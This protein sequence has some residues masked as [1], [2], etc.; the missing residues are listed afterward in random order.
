MANNGM[1][2]LGRTLLLPFPKLKARL[3]RLRDAYRESGKAPYKPTARV[4][5][6]HASGERPLDPFHLEEAISD[7]EEKDRRIEIAVRC[8][9][10]DDVP[11][12]AEAGAVHH[13]ED[14]TRVQIMHNGLRVLADGYYGDWNTRLIELCH[15]CHEPQEERV[16]HEVLQRLSPKATMIELGGYWAFYSLW[17]LSGGKERT[18]IVVEP[19]PKHLA[20]GEANA[21]LNGLPITFVQGFA[22][23]T[24]LPPTPFKTL[25]SG[26][27]PVPRVSVQSL[28]ENHGIDELNVLHCDIQGAEFEV[29]QGCQPLFRDRRIEF[30]FVSTHYFGPE[31]DPLIHQ[32]CLALILNC[33]GK[34]V[35]EHDVHESF[36]C[37]G[38][39]VAYFGDNS[40]KAGPVP[41]SLNRYSQ[42]YFRNP[43]YDV[44]IMRR[45][46]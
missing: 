36:S 22:G 4:D 9:D 2:A 35:A 13:L 25:T 27:I 42:T 10:M 26:E 46:R 40:E 19:D 17:F 5:F 1:L 33:G 12:V 45:R 30:L 21:R 14:G 20:V 6:D 37:D 16:F 28:M 29:L 7:V 18:S 11:R 15:G 34:I 39:I 32:R 24:Q 41:V 38:L 23:K 8:R 44:A 3:R 31:F 43:L